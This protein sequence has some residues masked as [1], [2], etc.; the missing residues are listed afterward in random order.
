M[1][2]ACYGVVGYRRQTLPN[3][4]RAAQEFLLRNRRA[5][6]T[7]QTKQDRAHKAAV[8]AVKSAAKRGDT[9]SVRELGRELVRSDRAKQRLALTVARLDQC[10]A[11]LRHAKVQRQM[12]RSVADATQVLADIGAMLSCEELGEI[13]KDYK[14]EMARYEVRQETIDQAMIA[15]DAGSTTTGPDDPE[16]EA[17]TAALLEVTEKRQTPSSSNN[18]QSPKMNHLSTTSTPASVEKLRTASTLLRPEDPVDD[19]EVTTLLLSILPNP[20]NNGKTEIPMTTYKQHVVVD[21]ED[22]WT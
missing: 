11:R 20:P 3:D 6:I 1:G 21:Q 12:A 14:R 7:E 10:L 22:M 2:N 17:V 8:T 5:I 16:D 18:K 19:N 4:M 9:T 13:A 15:L